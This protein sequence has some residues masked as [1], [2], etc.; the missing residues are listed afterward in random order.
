MADQKASVLAGP[1][2]G[3]A[4]R[5]LAA[6]LAGHGFRVSFPPGR[7]PAVFRVTG[8]PGGPHVEVTAE[9]DG[10]VS[11]Y[12]AGRSASEAARVIA[13]LPAPGR[14]LECAEPGDTVTAVWDG[15]EVE[16]HY[17]PLAGPVPDPG[18]AVMALL[19]HLAVLGGRRDEGDELR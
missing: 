6:R 15:I 12:Y 13:R 17:V 1:V 18:Q 8:L 3:A 4:A 16:W 2:T 9:G 11:C 14:S 5:S 10:P 19:A 7:D